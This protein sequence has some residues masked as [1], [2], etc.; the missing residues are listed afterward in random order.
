MSGRVNRFCHANVN[1]LMS[2]TQEQ[3][4]TVPTLIKVR[5]SSTMFAIRF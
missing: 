1:V 3:K 5:S 4:K 2:C